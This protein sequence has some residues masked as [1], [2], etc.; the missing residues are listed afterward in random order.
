M[1]ITI[2]TAMVEPN[3]PLLDDDGKACLYAAAKNI[4]LLRWELHQA[5]R[6]FAN[7]CDVVHGFGSTQ[8]LANTAE[9]LCDTMRKSPWA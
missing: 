7:T 8:E 5:Y 4:R 6:D 3:G 1:T 2:I 9:I